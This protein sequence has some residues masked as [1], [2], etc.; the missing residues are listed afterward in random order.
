MTQDVILS[1]LFYL[2]IA[3]TTI[4]MAYKKYSAADGQG[5]SF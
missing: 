4:Y 2:L 1:M 3:V 5:M